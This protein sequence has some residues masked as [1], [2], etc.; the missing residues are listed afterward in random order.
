MIYELFHKMLKKE[1]AWP[2]EFADL[3][4]ARQVIH[5]AFGD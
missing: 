3:R 1:Y 2:R 4:E 5:G